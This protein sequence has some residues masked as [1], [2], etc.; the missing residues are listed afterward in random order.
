MT[1]VFPEHNSEVEGGGEFVAYG[2][3]LPDTSTMTAW[4]M[5]GETRYDGEATDPPAQH[6]WAFVFEG[7]PTG[8]VVTLTVKGVSGMNDHA[9]SIDITCVT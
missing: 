9:P 2:N 3:V 5:D 4:I 8:R 7:I 1:I 6:V